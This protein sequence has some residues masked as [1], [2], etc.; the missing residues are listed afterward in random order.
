MVEQN[1]SNAV[2]INHQTRILHLTNISFNSE[3]GSINERI[4]QLWHTVECYVA[5]K[6]NNIHAVSVDKHYVRHERSQTQKRS[7][8]VWLHL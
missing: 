6:K 7:H 3:G 8:T 1:S 5:L 2:E 4:N